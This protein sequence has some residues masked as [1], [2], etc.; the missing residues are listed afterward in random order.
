M[1]E[2][3]IWI[4]AGAAGATLL[5]SLIGIVIYFWYI[6]RREWC[7]SANQVHSHEEFFSVSISDGTVS[8]APSGDVGSTPSST[9]RTV[10]PSTKNLQQLADGKSREQKKNKKKQEKNEKKDV[11]EPRPRLSM[12]EEVFY[13]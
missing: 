5:L 6:G 8:F 11:N 13:I 12:Y 9:N 1:E 3:L 10:T 7:R 4:A 2:K